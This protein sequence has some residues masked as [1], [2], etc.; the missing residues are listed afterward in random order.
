MNRPRDKHAAYHP[1]DDQ[2]RP[3]F[4]QPSPLTPGGRIDVFVN[5][6]LTLEERV[7][8]LERKMRILYGPLKQR[9]ERQ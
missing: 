1:P 6:S 4:N 2:S 3:S 8:E 5:H 7:Q 9:R